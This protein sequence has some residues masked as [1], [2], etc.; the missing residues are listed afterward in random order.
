MTQWILSL[1][2]RC[3]RVFR[4]VLTEL[5]ALRVG[6]VLVIAAALLL[7]V[8][9]VDPILQILDSLAGVPQKLSVSRIFPSI[10]EWSNLAS[11]GAAA[12]IGAGAYLE[13]RA[14]RRRLSELSMTLST[15]RE[16][17]S[18]VR[19]RNT[20]IPVREEV[21]SREGVI[22]EVPQGL[23]DAAMADDVVLVMGAGCSAQASLPT[24]VPFL[25]DVLDDVSSGIDRETREILRDAIADG[26][27]AATETLLATVGRDRLIQATKRILALPDSSTVPNLFRIL[28][29]RPWPAIIGLTWDELDLRTFGRRDYA[30]VRAEDSP[31]LSEVL[32]SSQPVLIKP[33]GDVL[34]PDTIALTWQ[35][36][37]QVLERWPDLVRGLATLFSTRT[38]FFIGLGLDSVE[39]FLN[40]LP[41]RSVSQRTHYALVP[42]DRANA[43]WQQGIGKRFNIQL[44]EMVPS[45]GYPELPAF[46]QRLF[47]QAPRSK[48]SKI[49]TLGGPR[50]L[51]LK[52]VRLK[53]IGLFENLELKFS[54]RWNVLLGVNGGGKSTVLK[55]IGL[56][57][58]GNDPRAEAAAQRLLRNGTSSGLIEIELGQDRIVVELSRERDRV[59][60]GAPPVT[61]VEAGTILA[62]GFPALRGVIAARPRVCTVAASGSF[63]RRSVASRYCALR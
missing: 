4:D 46:I 62:L 55:A 2:E 35:D 33:I 8:V 13:I 12:M 29:E 56:A 32:R 17:F 50:G 20:R 5:K 18:N 3:L 15:E 9:F 45:P 57:L 36:Y 41:P 30:I 52:S 34:Q 63:D 54:D 26:D 47:E 21:L 27:K 61:P 39:E 38:L 51:E 7:F 49:A 58:C 23:V 1:V 16:R 60:V 14:F 37:R 10:R 48:R 25:L 24:S 40:G 19:S 11:W 42:A 6:Q 31:R 43:V 44:I 22:P 28:A 59:R 53:N